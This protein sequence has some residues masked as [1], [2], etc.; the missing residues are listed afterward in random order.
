LPTT[1]EFDN[2]RV[3]LVGTRNPLNIGAAAR[4]M[5]NFGFRHLRF[6]NPYAI[7]FREAR[8]A[9][10]AS[11]LLAS[12]EEYDTVA[13]AVADCTLVVGS[14]AVRERE[15]HHPVRRLEYGGRLIRKQLA[16]TSVALLFGSERFGL[17]N[18]D[19]SH[20]HW[21]IRIPTGE[22]NISMNLGQAVAVCLYE[23]IR[24]ANAATKSTHRAEEKGP[25]KKLSKASKEKRPR[26]KDV[27]NPGDA[28]LP[29]KAADV[30]RLTTLLFEV[31]RRTRYWNPGSGASTEEKVRRLVR[32]LNI[33]AGDAE[34][35]L[36]ILRQ[37]MWKIR[38]VD[39][40]QN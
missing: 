12:A 9:V 29:A 5:S 8:S 35:W 37:I 4:A 16:S 30:E 33:P 36:G 17:S 31:L 11:A 39:K 18:A 24:D 32:R 23:L 2:L 26:T 10:G 20:C 40:L 3:V 19:L 25:N 7:A 27:V 34:V 28:N 22:Q 6:V 13:D 1:P 21:L 38:S 15:L 14:T